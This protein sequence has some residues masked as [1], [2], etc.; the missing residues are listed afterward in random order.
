MG[1]WIFTKSGDLDNRFKV[2]K[3]S[4]TAL[5]SLLA[6][7]V[8]CFIIFYF[9][10]L[11]LFILLPLALS[12]AC[13]QYSSKTFKATYAISISI[14]LLFLY[15]ILLGIMTGQNNDTIFGKYKFNGEFKMSEQTHYGSTMNYKASKKI[16]IYGNANF[17]EQLQKGGEIKG[18]IKK[19]RELISYAN[20]NKNTIIEFI[21]DAHNGNEE[22]DR[23]YYGF[24]EQKESNNKVT[25]EVIYDGNDENYSFIGNNPVYDLKYF[26]EGIKKIISFDDENYEG[27]FIFAYNNILIAVAISSLFSALIIFYMMYSNIG[28]LHQ[29]QI[30]PKKLV[31]NV[32]KHIVIGLL[33]FTVCLNILPMLVPES[34]DFIAVLL[35]FP[36]TYKITKAVILFLDKKAIEKKIS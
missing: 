31:I 20:D 36:L 28:T 4:K 25:L 19:Q 18:N 35:S 1:F 24:L 32:V 23:Y 6:I 3:D 30:N 29:I 11:Y 34:I 5:Y 15:S 17:I 10:Y 33:S 8:V 12:I 7:V 9:I 2:V 14:F 13:Y 22:V 26:N 16:N 21:N 27:G